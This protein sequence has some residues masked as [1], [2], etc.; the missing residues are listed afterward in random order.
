[1]FVKP[2]RCALIVLGATL[3]ACGQ[4]QQHP[5][6]MRGGVPE[7]AV[8]SV[9]PSTVELSNVYPAQ[10]RGR[11]DVEIRPNVSGF[12]TKLCVDEGS[13]VRKGQ[14]LFE[15]DPVQY[16]E[17]V[18][19]AEASVNVAKASVGTARLTAE[20]KRQLFG[21]N[22]I[23][24]Y[25][26]RMAEN[27]LA[28]AE[29]QLAQA[30]AQLVNAR[31]N[32]SYTKVTSPSN[33]VVGKVPFRVGS[34]V[35]PT[36]SV[37]LTTVSDD[38]QMY[39]Y[40]SL[41]EKEILDLLRRSEGSV[42]GALSQMPDVT[43][44]L[45]DGTIYPLTGKI[46]TLSGVID[47]ATGTSVVRALFD[48]PDRMLRSGGSGVVMLP[49]TK[50]SVLVVPQSATSE[51]QDKKYVFVVSDS[52]TVQQT[53][54]GILSVNDGKQYVVTSGLNPGD[55]IVAEGV[56]VLRNGMTIKPITPAEAAAKLQGAI[57]QQQAAAA[58]A[59]GK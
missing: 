54:I 12:I 53:E 19:I 17:A 55:R 6:M 28:Q 2:Q 22:I 58:A 44:K 20:N 34:L 39:A 49:V 50:D 46:E 13:V 38:S 8:V 31:K 33:G 27:T 23:S 1:M 21:K 52:S 57:Q 30:E 24:E 37:A 35:G 7:Y 26:M 3:C 5:G 45:A 43:L 14:V 41:N 10:I 15:I 25:D 32:L 40:F 42:Q 4:K 9:E 18:N 51:V 11:Q 16:Q 48:N 59:A 29:A 56:G 36:S 47:V